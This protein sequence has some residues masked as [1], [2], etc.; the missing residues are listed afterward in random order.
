MTYAFSYNGRR[1][2]SL[3]IPCSCESFLS[4]CH[5]PCG[6]ETPLTAEYTALE[7]RA[8]LGMSKYVGKLPYAELHPGP[9]GEPS[10]PA[11]STQLVWA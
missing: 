2:Q 9:S 10:L 5:L 6:R 1:V 8:L 4:V 11:V 3:F 7:S